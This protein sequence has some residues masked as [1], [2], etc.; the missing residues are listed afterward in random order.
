LLFHALI[1]AGKLLIPNCGIENA[2]S[3]IMDLIEETFS[4]DRVLLLLIEF[5][6][7][8]LEIKAARFHG[9]DENEK[10]ILSRDAIECVIQKRDALLMNSTE[11]MAAED[12]KGGSAMA[13]PLFD[14]TKVIGLL[15]AEKRNPEVY[16]THNELST[17]SHLACLL[18]LKISKHRNNKFIWD[19]G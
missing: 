8:Q 5:P 6:G 2:I 18:A 4:V 19:L 10:L 15:Y 16:F 1:E 17:F 7:G 9:V 3:Q 13:V 12:C 11:E 14:D